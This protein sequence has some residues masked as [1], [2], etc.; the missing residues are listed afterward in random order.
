M[1]VRGT[2][3]CH[4][5][6]MDVKDS[7]KVVI[8]ANGPYLISGAVPVALETIVPARDKE[9]ASWAWQ[10][11]RA[12]EVKARYALCRCG[13]SASK[14]FCDGTHA[15]IDFDG[16]ET[17]SHSPF[18][19][20]AKTLDGPDS[21]LRDA[22]PLCAFARFCDNGNGIWSDV[23]RTDDPAVRDLVHRE[24]AHCPSGRLVLR[25][26]DGSAIEP[27]FAPAISLV[28]DPEKGCSGPLW[29]KG[30]IAVE[31]SDGFTYEIRNRVALCRCGASSNKP[32]CDGTH[33]DVAFKDGL[34]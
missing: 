26:L 31:G 20:Q 18:D 22:E 30:G 2:R 14:P 1:L 17:A 10:T 34:A 24:A 28:E 13:S 19:E 12:I 29:V 5:T 27:A 33:A 6:P 21:V 15:K 4:T 8:A 3:L 16:T 32:F 9:G 23:A 11:G 25:R 7:A